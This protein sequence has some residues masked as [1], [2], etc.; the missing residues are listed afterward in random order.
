MIKSLG[1]I[2][3]FVLLLLSPV[4]AQETAPTLIPPTLATTPLPPAEDFLLSESTIARIQRSGILNVGILLNEPR[5]G[6]LNVRGEIVGF[7]ADL[8]RLLA[9]SWGVEAN[10]IQVTRQNG[11]EMLKKGKIDILLAAQVHYRELDD[12]VEFS[13]SYHLGSQTFLVRTD[14]TV[15]DPVNLSNRKVGYSGGTDGETA[16]RRYMQETGLS[17]ELI[18][19]LTLFEAYKALV[20][21]DVDAIIGR[22]ER[23]L[24]ASSNFPDAV[25]LIGQAL[26][27]EPFA[28]AFAR[29]DVN[30][31]NLINRSLQFY[32]AS[33]KLEEIYQKYFPGEA[34]AV[35]ALPVWKNIGEE[36]PKLDSV[37]QDVPYPQQY[38]APKILSGQTLRVAGLNDVPADAYEAYR[39]LDQYYRN[40]IAEMA[41]R[42][43]VTVEFIPNSAENAIELVENGQADLA[44][45][46]EAD[47]DYAN[48]VDFTQPI[49]LYGDRIMAPVKEEIQSFRDLRGQWIGVF[50]SDVGA[51]ERA[52][53][54]AD[55]V[56]ARVQFIQ[57][58]EINAADAILSTQNADVIFGTSWK[59][60]PHVAANPELELT[61]R[62]YSRHYTTF[63][64]PRND[65]DFRLLVEYTIQEMIKDGSLYA[66]L[67]PLILS[68]E[69][70]AFDVWPG[71]SNYYGLELNP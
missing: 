64:V 26:E 31:R 13:L 6:E 3:S 52:Q 60:V 12:D 38:L 62:W 54:L 41:R 2:I 48:R 65:L 29:Q 4:F 40:I 63:A 15:S 23:L 32:L 70:P 69:V 46:I 68:D 61:D 34:F 50:T 43:G 35:D 21:G 28:I 51:Q 14:D 9:E 44:V 10:F 36:A 49:F 71:S 8:A 20:N 5:F 67:S 27:P 25:K 30:F 42:W 59:L 22:R 45:G 17:F 33:G 66:A 19:Y 39:L 53:E 1:W 16:I 47:W 18:P 11:V 37:S 57:T 55:S 58:P 7:D 56:S 24:T